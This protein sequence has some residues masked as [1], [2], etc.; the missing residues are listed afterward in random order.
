[1]PI[2]NSNTENLSFMRVFQ[3]LCLAF[4]Y[5]INITT[6]FAQSSHINVGKDSLSIY[7]FDGTSYG[8]SNYNTMVEE[9]EDGILYFANENGLLEF[10]G[11]EW[12]LHK[13]NK[14]SPVVFLKII[15]DRIYVSDNYEF[16]YYQRDSL[17]Y[18]QYQ[19]IVP[20]L[21]EEGLPRALLFLVEH[22]SKLYLN[23]YDKVM[24]WDG[25]VTKTINVP[26]AHMF[27]VGNEILFS[28]YDEGLG[29]LK[30][31]T[32]EYVNTDFKWKYDAAFNIKKNYEGNWIIYTS[33]EG[34]YELDTIN[35]STKL[36]KSEVTDYFL[37]ND[38]DFYSYFE[39]ND[40]LNVAL[41]FEHGVVFY[42]KQGKILKELSGNEGLRSNYA[43]GIE[44]D[45][46]NNIWV[47][48]GFGIN[49]LKWHGTTNLDFRARSIIRNI[50]ATDSTIFVKKKSQLINLPVKISKELSFHFATPSFLKQ[51]LEYSFYL[52]GFEEDYSNWNQEVKKDYTNLP[53]GEYTFHVKAR[54]IDMTN[55]SIKPFSLNIYIPTPWYENKWSYVL[56]VLILGVLIFGFVR[57]RTQSLKTVNRKLE[58]LVS[59]RT[60]QLLDQQVQLREANEELTVINN[61]LDNFVYRSSH[62]LVAPLK[63]LRGLIQIAKLE[64]TPEEKEK[65]FDLM[66][67]SINK[68]EEFIKSIMDFSTNTKK[69]LE[70]KKVKLNYVLDS[71]VQD[72]KYYTHSDKV[73][74]Y[75]S[76]E[77][78]FTIETDSKRLNIVLSNLITNAV[79]YH[80]FNQEDQPF[81]E[82]KA[83]KKDKHYELRVS[84][85]GQGI[86]DEFHDKIFNMFFRAHQGIEGSGLGLYIVVDTLKVLQGE[87]SFTS[88]VRKGT[89]FIVKLPF[90]EYFF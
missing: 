59:E 48:N 64:Q 66:N 46:R 17:G 76:F 37:R 62:D 22:N 35:Y 21:N 20:Q 58:E 12:R 30:N 31:D 29:I 47:T 60:S 27:K 83:E 63:S 65:Y 43:L 38:R 14:Y 53:G 11:S 34:F 72:I 78:D 9:D 10:D 74:L 39:V 82:I 52:E 41:T 2:I 79:K 68:L 77:D 54:P 15:Q 18:M 51:E 23:T 70:F 90:K 33:E 16:G 80:N 57:I 85:N 75:R 40:T 36:W 4:V 86:P 42:T 44:V 3:L 89:E 28:V 6:I 84:D 88:K 24:V 81:I 45:R 8:A 25:E 61:E 67:T 7:S 56:M 69:P 13:N 50:S 87:I 49:Y 32:I 19:T 73:E 5:L 26:N 71:I 55:I 1:M